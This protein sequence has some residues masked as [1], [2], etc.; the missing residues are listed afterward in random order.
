[1]RHFRHITT[2]KVFSFRGLR[3]LWS[4][5]QGLC[6]GPRWGHSPQTA[7]IGSCSALAIRAY[8]AIGSPIS[9][10]GSALAQSVGEGDTSPNAPS[11]RGLVSRILCASCPPWKSGSPP[12]SPADLE[13]ATGLVSCESLGPALQAVVIGAKVKT[14]TV[15]TQVTFYRPTS[16]ELQAYLTYSKT[17]LTDLFWL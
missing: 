14:I 3:P 2:Q 11:P 10:A 16:I 13:L 4:L 6:P 8:M 1:M 17:L 12:P 15:I 9:T 7:V 5:D